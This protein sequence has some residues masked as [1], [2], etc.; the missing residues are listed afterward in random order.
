MGAHERACIPMVKR[1]YLSVVLLGLW[2]TAAEGRRLF[3]QAPKVAQAAGS[4]TFPSGCVAYWKMDEASGT[5]VDFFTGNDF[6]DSSSVG[7]RAGAANLAG[8]YVPASFDYLTRADTADVSIGANVDFTFSFWFMLDST[9]SSLALFSKTSVAGS[10]EYDCWFYTTDSKIHFY[11]WDSG[12]TQ[13]EAVST[14][15]IV[16]STKYN[17]VI[18]YDQSNYKIYVNAG[19]AETTADSNDIRDSTSDLTVGYSPF[20]SGLWLDGYLDEFGI[21][22][23]ALTSTEVGDIYNGGTPTTP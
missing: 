3:F 11:Y 16:V 13:R 1:I 2:A 12:G 5:R 10:E 22:K 7:S 18:T 8:D 9:A 23:R 4:P 14:T 15:S 17:V 20:W 6:T 21:W 19:S